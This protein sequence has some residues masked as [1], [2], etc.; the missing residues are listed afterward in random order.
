M[1]EMYA[2]KK[3][4]KSMQEVVSV[5]FNRKT[6]DEKIGAEFKNIED[7]GGW[8]FKIDPIHQ[9]KIGK[10]K[11]ALKYLEDMVQTGDYVKW[12]AT[13]RGDDGKTYKKEDGYSILDYDRLGADYRKYVKENFNSD[14]VD[15]EGGLKV[16]WSAITENPGFVKVKSS[17]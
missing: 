13:I 7:F 6:F 5:V 3:T 16:V 9:Y 8:T 12:P 14:I 4:T 1:A 10:I 11:E 17:Q 15:A 2:T